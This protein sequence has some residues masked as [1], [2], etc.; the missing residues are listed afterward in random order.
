MG[1]RGRCKRRHTPRY[2]RPPASRASRA[3]LCLP[4]RRRH[5]LVRAKKLSLFG[6]KFDR[7]SAAF[8][9]WALPCAASVVACQMAAQVGWTPLS[10]LVRPG[11]RRCH[12][13]SPCCGP[14]DVHLRVPDHIICSALCSAVPFLVFP[15][16]PM[17]ASVLSSCS[18]G[19]WVAP[20]LSLS[21]LAVPVVM[22]CLCCCKIT[23]CVSRGS[24]HV[25]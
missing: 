3:R 7:C 24:Q 1:H 14:T 6:A 15:P 9:Q 5:R 20:L 19:G 11:R 23:S 16:W 22:L 12:H 18:L 2:S 13:R 8:M 10:G 21:E 17:V 25:L 4:L